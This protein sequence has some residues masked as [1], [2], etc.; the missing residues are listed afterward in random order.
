MF[1]HNDLSNDQTS[2]ISEGVTDIRINIHLAGIK[3]DNTT[4]VVHE[5]TT[6]G[7]SS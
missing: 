2:L 4:H 7:H 5:D 6:S 1:G 3:P